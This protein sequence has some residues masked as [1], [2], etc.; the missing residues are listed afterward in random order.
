MAQCIVECVTLGFIKAFPSEYVV[1][2]T[3]G[4]GFGGIVGSG[5]WILCKA[6]GISNTTIFLIFMPLL[7]VY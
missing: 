7:L 5:S 1:G 6:I 2:F 4:T 3:S